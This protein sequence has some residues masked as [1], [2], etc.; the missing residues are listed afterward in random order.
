MNTYTYVSEPSFLME[1][2][3]YLKSSQPNNFTLLNFKLNIHFLTKWN[4]HGPHTGQVVGAT[5]NPSPSG[6]KPMVDVISFM[7]RK[8]L[9]LRWRRVRTRFCATFSLVRNLSNHFRRSML[10]LNSF[11]GT[12]PGGHMYISEY[13]H[14]LHLPPLWKP[15]HRANHNRARITKWRRRKILAGGDR[16]SREEKRETVGTPQWDFN[17]SRRMRTQGI[18]IHGQGPCPWRRLNEAWDV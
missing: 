8:N 1:N 7:G 6:L 10:N 2:H 13:A 4:L 5:A 12:D 18:D 17:G 3:L 15:Q 16:R 14:L 9:F 11:L